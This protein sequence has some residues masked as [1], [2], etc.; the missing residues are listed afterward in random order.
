MAHVY[1]RG[2]YWWAKIYVNGKPLYR[3]LRLRADQVRKRDAEAA[4]RELER[5]LRAGR[6]PVSP[7]LDWISAAQQYLEAYRV[8]D[9]HRP[10]THETRRCKIE[11]F[12]RHVGG[13]NPIPPE[14]SAAREIVADYL[15]SRARRWS[16]ATVRA[17]Q[18]YLHHW[19]GWLIREQL[20]PWPENPAD[21]RLVDLP[22]SERHT[23]EVLSPDEDAALAKALRGSRLWRLYCLMRWCGLRTGE[24]LALEW[25][26]VDLARSLLRIRETKTHRDRQIPIPD[27][28]RRE[29]QCWSRGSRFVAPSPTGKRWCRRNALRGWVQTIQEAKL[30]QSCQRPYVLRRTCIS[31]ALEA[32][33]SPALAAKLFGHSIET[34]MR[35]YA[36]V[37][38]EDAAKYLSGPKKVGADGDTRSEAC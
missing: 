29:M 6:E 7:T 18:R 21:R 24:A 1:R 10:Q 20:A 19:F 27:G 26:D 3:S 36:N 22:E 8:R 37:G 2:R 38:I 31:R 28:L 35:Y 11:I 9:R 4:G 33:L 5:R 12:C 15:R 13:K 16:A 25:R 32:G 14:A 23:P 30:P 34:M 17:D